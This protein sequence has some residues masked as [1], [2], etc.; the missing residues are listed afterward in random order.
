MKK[1]SYEI[2]FTN[3]N[4][5]GGTNNYKPANRKV[6]GKSRADY[7][8]GF[9]AGMSAHHDA[10]RLQRQQLASLNRPKLTR[11]T[12]PTCEISVDTVL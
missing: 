2:G 1:K 8:A 9:Q 3:G 5:F 12:P 7:D 6:G 10:T 11:G 4:N